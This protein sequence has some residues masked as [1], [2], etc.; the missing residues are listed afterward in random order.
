VLFTTIHLIIFIIT[1]LVFITNYFVAYFDI[2]ALYNAH[3][4]FKFK[5][6]LVRIIRYFIYLS[7][8]SKF[9]V[10]EEIS[11]IVFLSIVSI[12]IF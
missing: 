11:N 5:T 12:V 10:F 9:D 7:C 6:F 8:G 4:C 2:I 1:I 3:Y